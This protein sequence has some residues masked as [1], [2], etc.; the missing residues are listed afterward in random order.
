M[1]KEGEQAKR[2]L[3]QCCCGTDNDFRPQANIYIILSL[4]NLVSIGL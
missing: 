4:D 1:A 3:L 2:Q